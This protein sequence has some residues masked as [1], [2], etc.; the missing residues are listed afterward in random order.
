MPSISLT[1][2]SPYSKTE[3]YQKVKAFL[4]TDQTLRKLDAQL[5]TSF[6]DEQFK[7]RAKGKQFEAQFVVVDSQGKTEVQIKVDLPFTMALFKGQI[8]S[9]LKEKLS[10][11]LG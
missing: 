9:K 11:V 2:Q 8:E 3:T 7:A 5:A 10:H 6:E 4:D 1:T